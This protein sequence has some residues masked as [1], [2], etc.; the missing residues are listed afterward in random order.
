MALTK[1][2]FEQ[3]IAD[4]KGITVEQLRTAVQVLPCECGE[5]D[6]QGW[7]V[8]PLLDEMYHEPILRR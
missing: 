8:Q 1:E 6:C 2:Q 3:G 5:P 7:Q 4:K